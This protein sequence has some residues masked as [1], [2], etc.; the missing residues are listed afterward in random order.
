[1]EKEP[2]STYQKIKQT[3][4]W[5]MEDSTCPYRRWYHFIM[6]TVLVLSLGVLIV[7]A[8]HAHDPERDVFAHH[9]LF[10]FLDHV[11]YYIFVCEY[12]LRWWTSTSLRQ[13]YR[14]AVH[15]YRRRIYH[16]SRHGEVLDGLYHA[17]L[18][19][20]R[21]MIH[22]LA[23]IDLLAILP[24]FR[25]F[26]LFRVIQLL[27]FFRY[28]R[29]IAFV[30]SI[31]GERRYEMVSLFLAGVVIWGTVAV[32]FFLAEYG[33]NDKVTSLGAAVYWSIITITT[34]GYGDISPVTDV[35]RVVAAV[36][37]L[38]GMSI[39][40]LMTSLVVSV[41]TDR[42]FNLK[43]FHMERQIERLRNHFIVC[44]L[45]ALGLVACQ[46]LHNEKKPFVAIDLDQTRVDRAIR[47][48]W[49]AIQGDV[50]L[51]E[52][53]E[54]VG[55]AR[56]SGVI[57]AILNEATNVYIILLVR[58]INAK[59][60]VVACGGQQSSEQRLQRV[61]ADRVVL[62]FQNAGQ[63]MAQTALR[64]GALQFFR[65]ALDQTHS[66]FEM[67]EISIRAGSVFDG[68][69]L[70]DSDLRHGF[71]AIVVGIIS[72]GQ[73]MTYNPQASHILRSGDVIICLGHK[74]DLER[75]KR[76][77]AMK[78]AG[79]PLEDQEVAEFLIRHGSPLN[80]ST[81]QEAQLRERFNRMVVA[82]AVGGQEVL[83]MPKP[84][85]RFAAGDVLVCLGHREQ[86]DA[87]SAA[88]GGQAHPARP[89]V[90]LTME[91]VRIPHG[92]HMQ[93]V[94]LGSSGIRV[95]FSCNVLAV[96]RPGENLLFNP[97]PDY[98]FAANDLLV[99]L[100]KRNDLNRLKAMILKS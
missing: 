13:D 8:H 92:S 9:Q 89:L 79:N 28:S 49:I 23:L 77:S 17:A 39:T 90:E 20:V 61:G 18:H 10:I 66:A 67:E 4:H 7:N 57:I 97:A 85:L 64:P 60:F 63:Q 75:L 45:D 72:E 88:M 34:V 14:D 99:C 98:R 48:G 81:L 26:R 55:L 27:K 22:P 59:C 29:R 93:G 83:F 74:D 56:A 16:S 41:F 3:V 32:A 36:G 35:G 19:K 24:T 31:L 1:M 87:M 44:G 51:Q 2:R 46:S 52:T 47:E 33:V 15:R 25:F 11:F 80:G 21:W 70:R 82:V 12:L 71:N 30:T 54:R 86:L 84:S 37:V 69:T 5:V 43:E 53:W 78:A 73:G 94:L 95:D 76:A 58:E 62:P 65:L 100:G 42:L 91:P 96:Q 38:V 40:V 6:M 68:V 50:T